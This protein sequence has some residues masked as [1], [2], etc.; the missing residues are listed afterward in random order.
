M[1]NIKNFQEFLNE[2]L[3]K[4]YPIEKVVSYI[5]KHLN[6]T[7]D[8]VNIAYK[9]TNAESIIVD[10][11][12]DDD[13]LN[14][15]KDI[16]KLG[17]YFENYKEDGIL[18]Y[19]KTFGEEVFQKLKDSGEVEYLYHITQ[20]KNDNKIQLQGLIPKHKNPKFTYPERVFLLSDKNLINHKNFINDFCV[21]LM[22]QLNKDECSFSIYR[23]DYSKLNNIKL[24]IIPNAKDYIGYY[25]TDSIQPDLLEKIDEIKIKI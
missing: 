15:I 11:T 9:G 8:D 23:I 2:G 19:D 12:L 5:Q 16:L 10:G 18:F 22:K 24:Y 20:S 3:I 21:H 25:T 1:N 14:K 17:G 13:V 4:T 7:D 6:L